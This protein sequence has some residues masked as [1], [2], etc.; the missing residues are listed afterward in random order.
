MLYAESTPVPVLPPLPSR[1]VPPGAG[2]AATPCQ[3]VAFC[4]ASRLAAVLSPNVSICSGVGPMKIRSFCSQVRTNDGL[5]E[6][7]PYPGCRASQ[8]VVSAAPMNTSPGALPSRASS[9][10]SHSSNAS[11]GVP[12]PA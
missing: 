11:A 9:V 8:P 4:V 5:S 7:N 10:V 1:A 6:R 3:F 12:P 2:R